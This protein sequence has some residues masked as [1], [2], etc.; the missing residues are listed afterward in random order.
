MSKIIVPGHGVTCLID[1]TIEILTQY[2][3]KS[4]CKISKN[5]LN[6]KRE[7]YC[8][9]IVSLSTLKSLPEPVGTSADFLIYAVGRIDFRSHD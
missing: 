8:G 5:F 4:D 9:A 3:Q 2:R 7:D 6:L 1:F